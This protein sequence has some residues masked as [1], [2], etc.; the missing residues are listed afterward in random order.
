MS[1]TALTLS[2][3]LL[4]AAATAAL[5]FPNAVGVILVITA[6]AAAWIGASYLQ[7]RTQLKRF[8][9]EEC[10]TSTEN[11]EGIDHDV[12]NSGDKP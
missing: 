7:A 11:H 10:R 5:I 6:L 1:R 9:L 12:N 4:F 8:M 3:V 2:T